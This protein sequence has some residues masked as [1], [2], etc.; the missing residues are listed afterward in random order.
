MTTSFFERQS[1]R[2]TLMASLPSMSIGDE[3]RRWSL[4]DRCEIESPE[5]R[6]LT[7]QIA[8]EDDHACFGCEHRDRLPNFD[9]EYE[10]CEWP[11]PEPHTFTRRLEEIQATI[12]VYRRESDGFTSGRTPQARTAAA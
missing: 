2:D 9:A 4:C 12:H 11:Y 10:P 1:H 7:E 3:C 8:W 6:F 5:A